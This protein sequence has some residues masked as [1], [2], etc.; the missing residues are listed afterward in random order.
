MT[1]PHFILFDFREGE[2]EEKRF[3]SYEQ[4]IDYYQSVLRPAGFGTRYCFS[5]ISRDDGR[6]LYY[7]RIVKEGSSNGEI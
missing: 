5:D 2:R 1:N 3:T 6:Y 7:L 4:Y